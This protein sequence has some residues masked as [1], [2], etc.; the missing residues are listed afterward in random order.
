[1]NKNKNSNKNWNKKIIMGTK[2]VFNLEDLEMGMSKVRVE[3]VVSYHYALTAD[4]CH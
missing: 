2:V 4:S 1:M 3:N